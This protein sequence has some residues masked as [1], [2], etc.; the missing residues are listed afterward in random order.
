MF[1]CV[2][3]STEIAASFSKGVHFNTFGGNPVAC[4]IASSVL[5][6]RA[7]PL[8]IPIVTWLLDCSFDGFNMGYLAT[9][10]TPT[11]Y[12][13]FKRTA[14]SRSAWMWAPTS[15]PNWPSCGTSTRSS[16]TSV[17]KAC[18][19]A[20]RWWKTR[21]EEEWRF[22]VYLPSHAR[23]TCPIFRGGKSSPGGHGSAVPQLTISRSG[24]SHLYLREGSTRWAA[25]AQRWTF[26][27][28][29]VQPGRGGQKPW[30]CEFALIKMELMICL[31]IFDTKIL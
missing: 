21:W 9:L 29:S 17:A 20:W 1:V 13:Q 28:L 7:H 22:F 14:L 2:C 10:P 23:T 11:D 6:V 26:V 3:V 27:L 12:R 30:A 16:A 31:F 19:S 8:R 18:R 5:D 15:W 25:A 4:A 24:R